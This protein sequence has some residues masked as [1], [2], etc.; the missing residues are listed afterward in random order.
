MKTPDQHLI[1]LPGLQ[2]F[3]DKAALSFDQIPAERKM[4]LEE[5]SA[6]IKTKNKA[7]QKVQLT[8]ICTHNSRR[9]HI[10]QLMAQ[11]AAVYYG[12]DNVYCYS[13]GT[14]VTAFNENA[15]QALQQIGFEVIAKDATSNPVY[16]VV[17]AANAS[18]MMAFSKLYTHEENPQKEYGAVLTC[19]SADASCP[20]VQ[21]ADA[22]FKLPYEDPKLSD[23]TPK[24]NEVY[25]ERSKQIGIE[26][27][28]IFSK[29][30]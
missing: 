9:S 18:K 19:S 15:V 8:F 24:Q 13:G 26:M 14:E 2:L 25:L 17:F 30:K 5:I 27:L 29:V 1:L 11:A 22:R 20:I 12:V 10:S 21:G 4:A 3:F 16:E 6:Y 28:Y 7:Q 23:G